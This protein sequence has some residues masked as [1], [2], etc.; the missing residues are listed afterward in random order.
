VL[1]SIA[2]FEK[3]HCTIYSWAMSL[4]RS[5]A[6][7][8][9]STAIGIVPL[10][11]NTL[12]SISRMRREPE[13]AQR[14][15]SLLRE[16]E[17]VSHLSPELLRRAIEQRC[18]YHVTPFRS[19]LIRALELPQSSR[20]LE[21]GCGGGALT[22]YLGEQG[23]SVTALETSEE[24]AE[25][26]R[27]R[28][29]DLPNVEV[30]TGFLEHVLVDYRFDFVIC[31][32]PLFV[33]SEFFDPGVQLMTLCR[34]VLKSTGTLILSVANPLHSPGDAHVEPS[35]DHVRGKG[36]P[37]EGIKRSLASAGF[38]QCEEYLTFPNHAAPRLLLNAN[39][40]LS[41]RV[42]WIPMV[43][44][45]YRASEAAQ[46]EIE[47]WWRAVY[48]E[49]LERQLAPGWLVL[50]HNHS[51]HSV[52]WSAGEGKFFTAVAVPDN[53]DAV[54]SS[55]P[56][57]SQKLPQPLEQMRKVQTCQLVLSKPELVRAVLTVSRPVVNGVRDY[58]ESL[59]AA[60][61]RIDELAFRESIAR[62]QLIDTQEALGNAEQRHAVELAQEQEEKRIREAELGLVLKQYHAVGAMCHDM[63]EEGRK[64]KDM[65]DELKR[66]YVA[67]EEW[68]ST[69]SQ[70]VVEA[71]QELQKTQASFTYRWSQILRRLLLKS[72]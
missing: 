6:L 4:H 25:C 41:E 34:K 51:V 16:V 31:V 65:L 19:A 60:D 20:V 56:N 3:D 45:L 55:D 47:R 70:R 35:V 42:S 32:D 71:E 37:L 68:G 61:Q 63:R 26:A 27:L 18:W 58:K 62:E 46:E 40:D 64:L 21:V 69:L 36:A 1:A 29:R 52:L 50:A 49:G 2:D 59:V 57:A 39:R 44:E 13:E 33:E 67:A 53:N 24:L 30:I 9:P 38:A 7:Q 28:C 48:T 23:Y 72:V 12:D 15:G 5:A 17:D 10:A 22:R 66:R 43:K 54:N 11:A 8:V 14:L